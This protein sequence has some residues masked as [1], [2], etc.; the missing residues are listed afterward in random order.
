[1]KAAVIHEHGG[2]ESIQMEEGLSQ[3][4]P[5]R[6][7]ILLDVKTAALNHLDLFVCQGMP[8]LTLDF[9]HILGS[10]AA[11]IVRETGSGVNSLSPG[12]QVMINA[13]KSCGA[14]EA[15]YSG[16]Q[17][18]CSSFHLLGEHSSGTYAEYVAVP[19]ENCLKIPE[20]LSFRKAAAFPLVFMTAWRMIM[21]RAEL[22]AGEWI[23]LH[24]IGGGVSHAALQIA[25]SIETTSIVTSSSE[26][27]CQKA[28][29]LG[30]DYTIQY[31]NEDVE[32]QVKEITNGRGVDVVVENVGKETWN[33]SQKCARKG[34]RIVT[35]GAT[36]GPTPQTN[37]NRIFWKQLNILGST[38]GS[39]SDFR[40]VTNWIKSTE[41][42]PAIDR[43]FPLEDVVEAE[44]R[45]QNGEQ[46]G[47]IV[48]EI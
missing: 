34:G 42:T 39:H 29:D 5:D 3:P 31:T 7:E 10:D 44:K 14:C 32:K 2:P 21:T 28:V 17:S 45:L 1:M 40:E 30:A 46:F 19:A 43:V 35:C 36:T 13:G 48:L 26:N 24:G 12:D 11:G 9:P 37:I 15:C 25:S 6:D 4:E 38:M 18:L 27:K 20:F 8:G 47:K 16:E 41:R 23:L 33:T 22:K